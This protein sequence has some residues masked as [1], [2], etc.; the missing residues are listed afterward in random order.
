[1]VMAVAGLPSSVV[2]V[3]VTGTEPLLTTALIDPLGD[4][5]T[6]KLLLVVA[7]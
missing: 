7:L 6:T 5:V 3:N 1:M 4:C 2:K